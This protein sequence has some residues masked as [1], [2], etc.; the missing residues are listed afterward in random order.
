MSYN[1]LQ[2]PYCDIPELKNSQILINNEFHDFESLVNYKW[3]TMSGWNRPYPLPTLPSNIIIFHLFGNYNYPLNNLP[4]G[5]EILIIDSPLEYPLENLPN[6]L[7]QLEIHGKYN[8]DIYSFPESIRIL[9]LY[10]CKTQEFSNVNVPRGLK[11]LTFYDT[12]FRGKIHLDLELEVLNIASYRIESA[13]THIHTNCT[14]N[15]DLLELP[16]TLKELYLPITDVFENQDTM[17]SRLV[18]L[19]TLQFPNYFN[20]PIKTYPPR[21]KNLM[22]SS[23]YNQP[24]MNLPNSVIYLEISGYEQTLEYIV[25]SNVE[26]IYTDNKNISLLHHLPKKL[27]KLSIIQTHHEITKLEEQHPELEIIKLSDYDYQE[28]MLDCWRQY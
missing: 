23:P 28:E 19:E 2:T 27:K 11:S 5:L 9:D 14:D 22:F 1:Y 15:F 8:F 7:Y 12:T 3:I 10:G 4:D 21:L 16:I 6:S 24:I 18:N 25:D 13:I 17:L 26:E 20:Q